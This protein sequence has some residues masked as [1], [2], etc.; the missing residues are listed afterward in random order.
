MFTPT[1]KRQLNYLDKM[2][3]K[4]M[5]VGVGLVSTYTLSCKECKAKK[6]THCV[7]VAESFIHDHEGHNTWVSNSGFVPGETFVKG[8]AR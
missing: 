5:R 3:I 8:G 6:S 4:E 2:L 1:Q 7:E